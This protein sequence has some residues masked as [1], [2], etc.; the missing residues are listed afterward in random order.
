MLAA[1]HHCDGAAEAAKHLAE[2][3]A[4]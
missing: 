3:Q 2:F 1:L 4:E